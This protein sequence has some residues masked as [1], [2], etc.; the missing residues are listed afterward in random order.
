MPSTFQIYLDLLL[1]KLTNGSNEPVE[2]SDEQMQQAIAEVKNQIKQKGPQPDKLDEEFINFCNGHP[3]PENCR[4]LRP[5]SN[6][7][8]PDN[9]SRY[10]YS[11]R[12]RD[13]VMKNVEMRARQ[14]LEW[15]STVKRIGL[16]NEDGTIKSVPMGRWLGQLLKTDGS[17]E[18][19]RFNES[20]VTLAAL[21]NN[22]ISKDEYLNIRKDYYIK[23]ENKPEAEAEKSAQNDFDNR[24]E[25]LYAE[26]EKAIDH[27]RDKLN[28]YKDAA[29]AIM[30]G[31]FSKFGGSMTQA[32]NVFLGYSE[33]LAM[34]GINMF[35]E[36][37]QKFGLVRTP[38]QKNEITLRWQDYTTPVN[39]YENLAEQVSNPYFA[40]FDPYKYYRQTSSVDTLIPSTEAERQNELA[41]GFMHDG[42]AYFNIASRSVNETLKQYGL[43]AGNEVIADRTDEYNVY[44]NDG[45]VAI[46]K[47]GKMTADEITTNN[48]EYMPEKIVIQG[49]ATAAN[50]L[51]ERCA[52]W[53]KKHRT[54]REFE[55]MRASLEEITKLG[56]DKNGDFEDK[57]TTS[58]EK[59]EELRADAKAYLAHKLKQHPDKKWDGDY[60]TARVNF[61]LDVLDFA[62]KKM[63][64]IGYYSR[65]RSTRIMRTKAELEAQIHPEWKNDPKYAGMSAVEHEL[66]AKRELIAKA[67]QA[68]NA[69]LEALQKEQRDAEMAVKLEDGR[70]SAEGYD[71]L[72]NGLDGNVGELDAA[73]N[74][75][76]QFAAEQKKAYDAEM[77]TIE[78]EKLF[79]PGDKK[80]NKNMDI[81]VR[82]MFNNAKYLIAGFVIA[83]LINGEEA[84]NDNLRNNGKEN[85][86]KTPIRQLVN[87]GKTKELAE[88]IIASAYFRSKF[89]ERLS[90]PESVNK[91]IEERNAPSKRTRIECFGVGKE[92]LE[93]IE[94]AKQNPIVEQNAAPEN[95]EKNREEPENNNHINIIDD[96]KNVD[97]KNG[98]DE[99]LDEAVYDIVPEK[100]MSKPCAKE[101]AL[102][103]SMLAK[104]FEE[105]KETAERDK[106]A[107]I[108]LNRH[109]ASSIKVYRFY[110]PNSDKSVYRKVAI[111]QS[112]MAL[113]GATLKYMIK[114]EAPSEVLRDA[115]ERGQTFS[116]LQLIIESGPFNENFKN[117]SP[118]NV[119]MMLDDEE[120]FC[121]PV[122]DALLEL[123]K[124]VI[125]PE[126][127]RVALQRSKEDAEKAKSGSNLTDDEKKIQKDICKKFDD[128]IKFTD[129]YEKCDWV[130]DTQPYAASPSEKYLN[131]KI[132]R[133]QSSYETFISHG[134]RVL[135]CQNV[136]GAL[137]AATMKYMITNDPT[138]F[139][140]ETLVQNNQYLQLEDMI[141]QSPLFKKKYEKIDTNNEEQVSDYI[142]DVSL[143]IKPLGE[144]LL[145]TLSTPLKQAVPK[146]AEIYKSD[147]LKKLKNDINEYKKMS[148]KAFADGNP[149]E[150]ENYAAETLA[151]QT[152][153]V[154]LL[155]VN[156]KGKMPNCTMT[157]MVHRVFESKQFS[158]M[159][160]RYDLKKPGELNRAISERA[161]VGVV[162][163]IVAEQKQK[164]KEANELAAGKAKVTHVN[165]ENPQ[166]QNKM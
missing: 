153:S 39:G 73:R 110:S 65:C 45:R 33:S 72:F 82:N 132:E 78:T 83:E 140:L 13:E 124:D 79:L 85:E 7:I 152:T 93:N 42:M 89:S 34:V 76:E 27:D 25:F 55:N 8:G 135:A 60:E 47:I 75:V 16:T 59:F 61:A 156:E 95:K 106:T 94:L 1:D 134:S 84:R 2:I 35:E 115:V 88:L 116:M 139:V 80:W 158:D 37:T 41:Y 112:A 69:K 40:I 148:E 108:I 136:V 143:L 6:T 147:M 43:N 87:A 67:A 117:F 52:G 58:A 86:I 51:V 102:F 123:A 23:K 70:R 149:D 133:C 155:S 128:V 15:R 54:S 142:D 29:L 161:S 66:E 162:K 130:E 104:R 141:S 145:D 5:D 165:P 77:T 127:V 150:A 146:I 26:V 125:K 56:F 68:E 22:V 64:Q 30:N 31:N 62:E 118:E 17:D 109:I 10:E 154:L 49:T 38:E 92:F 32:F 131:E 119:N 101:P 14:A 144:E 126:S 107:E 24:A 157:T 138:G 111:E 46:L 12:C 90:E 97:N 91:L 44:E 98:N 137:T 9:I 122:G 114:K 18:S 96:D 53:S 71:K 28:S 63:R 160:D 129:L 103:K 74:T 50:S 48:D 21:G 120:F 20:V 113:A 100:D 4:K 166:A 36:L 57:I 3:K 159:L 99:E 164:T 105:A 81:A 163:S 19:L 121:R 151:M 11:E